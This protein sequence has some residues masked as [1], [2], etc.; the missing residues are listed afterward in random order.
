MTSGRELAVDKR[1]MWE[2][3]GST[4]RPHPYSL[5]SWRNLCVSKGLPE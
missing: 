1:V 5:K 2:G 3:Q 4:E